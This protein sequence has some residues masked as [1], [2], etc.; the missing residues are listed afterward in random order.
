MAET[1]MY[2]QY[3]NLKRQYPDCLL[4]FRLGDFYEAFESDAK[5]ISKVLGITLTGRGKGDNRIPMAGIPHHALKQYLPKLVKNGHKVAIAD[6][7]EPARSGKL[8][9]RDVVKVFTAGTIVDESMLLA[10][11]NNYIASIACESK[12]NIW[13]IAFCDISTGEF[14]VSEYPV[15]NNE[16]LPRKLLEELFR[17]KPVELLV[18][19]NILE[20]IRSELSKF[21]LQVQEHSDFDYLKNRRLLLEN[22]DIKSLKPFGIE[23]LNRAIIASGVLYQYLLDTQ[24]TS[25]KHIIKIENLPDR[26]YMLLDENAIQSLELFSSLRGDQKFTL[27]NCLNYCQTPMGQRLLGNWL[28]RPLQRVDKIN[29]R[30]DNVEELVENESINGVITKKLSEIIDTQRLLSRLA[31]GTVNARDLVFMSKSLS[32]AFE[33]F[34]IINQNNFKYLKENLPGKSIVEDC[35]EIINLIN[36]SIKEDPAITITEGNMIKVGYNKDL[37]K[38]NADAQKG[39]EYIKSLQDK[40]RKRTG[41]STLKVGFNNVFGY[42]LEIRKSSINNIPDDYIRKQTLVNAERFITEELKQWEDIVLTAQAKASEIEYEILGSIRKIIIDKITSLGIINDSIA[43]IDVYTNFAN[44]TER[45][46]LTRPE[47]SDD[48]NFPTEIKNSRHLIV[49]IYTGQDFVPNDVAFIQNEQEFMLI[50]GPNMSGKST[51]IRQV[52]LLFIMAQIGCFVP[53]DYAKFLIAD[54]IFTRIGS[55]DNLAG[56]ESTFMVEMNETANILNNVTSRSLIILDEIGRGTSTYDGLSLAWAIVEYIV[57]VIKA[58]TLFAT[59][60]HELVLL[61]DKFPSIKNYNVEVKEENDEVVFMHRIIRG[62]TDR[63]YGVYVAKIS[64]IPS[65]VISRANDVLH[66]LENN[67][68]QKAFSPT[69]DYNQQL[70]FGDLRMDDDIRE[71]IKQIDINQLTPLGALLQIKKL[72]ED[73]G[74][75]KK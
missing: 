16:S 34:E 67:Q 40:E 11:K 14:R 53:A 68:L 55:A 54:K 46:K 20:S 33:I 26:E 9:D 4:L 35:K 42:F 56:G 6:Q 2:S 43:I 7:L 45:Y 13:G 39:R 62:A 65:D 3:L 32:V 73:I 29:T 1:P 75:N 37:D 31:T 51:Y 72:Q 60:Y 5:T 61:E 19:R 63:S 41:I 49:E 21:T 64:G 15:E 69:I 48:T 23:K 25:L 59:H 12:S 52:A 71:R 44:I 10:H 18:D 28:L 36:N 70:A 30:F 38:I 27:F 50:T 24:K 74:N 17:I 58:R 22:F 66:S 8:V 57:K 47:I